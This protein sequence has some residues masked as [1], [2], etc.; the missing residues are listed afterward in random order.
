[1]TIEQSIIFVSVS[2]LITTISCVLA[3]YI[4]IKKIFKEKK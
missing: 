3:G 1:M 2:I 4:I